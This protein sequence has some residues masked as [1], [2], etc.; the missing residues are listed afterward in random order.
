MKTDILGTVGYLGGLSSVC[1][2]FNWCWGQMI[3]FTKEEISQEIHY[4]R[5][6]V[7]FHAHARNSLVKQ[8]KGLFLLQLDTDIE[9][10]PDLVVRMLDRMVRYNLDVL[11][12]VYVSG[13]HP[14]YPIL[15]HW[16]GSKYRNIGKWDKDIIEIGGAG[17]GVLMVRKKI[18]DHIESELGES[19]FDIRHPRGEDLSFFDRLREIGV[20]T[21]CDTRIR[22]KHLR[23]RGYDLDDFDESYISSEENVIVHGV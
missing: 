12:G 22:V 19:P 6:K 13:S 10:E 2:E 1:E 23:P 9:F 21:Y 3:L 4:C 17:G 16:D 7:S 18:F 11:T 15:Y 8:T 14:H 5:S 20:K